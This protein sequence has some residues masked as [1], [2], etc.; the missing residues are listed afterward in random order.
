M[1][2]VDIF[3]LCFVLYVTFIFVDITF[4]CIEKNGKEISFIVDNG[5]IITGFILVA[6][7]LLFTIRFSQLFIGK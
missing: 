7:F 6:L 3:L 5:H 1:L 4:E 2:Y